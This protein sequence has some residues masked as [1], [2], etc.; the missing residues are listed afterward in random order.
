MLA[1]T[2]IAASQA[3]SSHRPPDYAQVFAAMAAL[4]Q[5]PTIGSQPRV[6]SESRQGPPSEGGPSLAP[7]SSY[8]TLLPLAKRYG[9][10][11]TS[12]TSG[13]H[14]R[15]SYH[16]QGR[17]AD[18]AGDPRREAALLRYALSH[19]RQ[20]VEAFY[21]GPGAAPY[22]V[23]NGRVYPIAQLDR[24]VRDNHHDHVHLAR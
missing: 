13:N 7:G 11:V 3:S 6:T 2:L 16:Y 12:T 8:K 15:G 9:L 20:F 4:R 18:I 22:Y 1:Q 10:T 17:A 23:K 19:P 5:A 14:V 24:S 21:T